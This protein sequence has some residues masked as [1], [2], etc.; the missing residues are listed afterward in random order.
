MTLEDESTPAPGSDAF[1]W[2]FYAASPP[3]SNTRHSLQNVRLLQK[4]F[5]VKLRNVY[6][7]FVIYAN[8]DGYSPSLS[9]HAAQ[10]VAKRPLLD[11][12]MLSELAL[13]VR[14]VR[15][16]LTEYRV[17]DAAQRLVELAEGISN[18]YVRRSRSRFWAPGF[19]QDKKDAF[20]TLFETLTTLSQLIAPFVPFFA[21]E[22]Y[23]NLVVGS[24]QEGARESVH[25]ADYPEA[26]AAHVD[27]DFDR[28]NGSGAG[29][30]QPGTGRAHQQS[31]EGAPALVAGGCRLQRWRFD[32]TPRSP[33]GADRRRAQRA[34]TWCSCIR[35][36]SKARSASNSNRTSVPWARAWVRTSRR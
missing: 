8:I 29:S 4:D 25:L 32:E 30:R 1:R 5:L 33:Q 22:V 19:E 2:F 10:P 3:W 18:W 11:R 35:G 23:Q 17:Y 36:T 34:T 9:K 26:Q 6:S 12:W 28:G 24:G 27:R 16:A 14:E 20:A 31:T 13:T 7:F 15:S 21:E